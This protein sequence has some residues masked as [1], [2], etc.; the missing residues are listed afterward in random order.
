M[1]AWSFVFG[2]TLDGDM[3]PV[4][5]AA[6]GV[7]SP[8]GVIGGLIVALYSSFSRRLFGY[9]I[10]RLIFGSV[11]VFLALPWLCFVK[12]PCMLLASIKKTADDDPAL[13][14]LDV[15][16]LLQGT[17]SDIENSWQWL[18]SWRHYFDPWVTPGDF[19][20]QVSTTSAPSNEYTP[21]YPDVNASVS[22]EFKVGWRLRRRY[23][24]IEKRQARQATIKLTLGH[25]LSQPSGAGP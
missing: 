9:L 10:S 21:D 17:S 23:R 14:L 22:A 3:H 25:I 16:H 15:L 18:P 12:L 7:A 6:E 20:A 11:F 8:E 4:V 13:S 5:S 19:P 1:V 2:V 24:N